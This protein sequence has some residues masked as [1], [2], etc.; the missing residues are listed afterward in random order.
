MRNLQ[1]SET[2][3]TFDK[4]ATPRMSGALPARP[5]TSSWEDPEPDTETGD[6]FSGDG[7]IPLMSGALQPASPEPG[8]WSNNQPPPRPRSVGFDGDYSGHINDHVY[9]TWGAPRHLR[10]NREDA[11]VGNE[12]AAVSNDLDDTWHECGLTNAQT[13]ETKRSA[14]PHERGS[15]YADADAWGN[16][17]NSSKE[18]PGSRG[19]WN[20]YARA[21]G[22]GTTATTEERATHVDDSWGMGNQIST[23]RYA[24]NQASRA[25]IPSIPS[26]E[27]Y[28]PA[29]QSFVS[30]HYQ[31]RVAN[32]YIQNTRFT[33]PDRKHNCRTNPDNYDGNRAGPDGS[34]V[35]YSAI[36][37][38]VPTLMD[39]GNHAEYTAWF[40]MLRSVLKYHQLTSVIASDANR[41]HSYKDGRR[42]DQDRLR[43]AIIIKGALSFEVF[44][45][46]RRNG[47]RDTDNPAET[48]EK[49]RTTHGA[50]CPCGHSQGM[51]LL[52]F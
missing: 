6:G 24:N 42:W 28:D 38:T 26:T 36:L 7:F 5:D 29:P 45:R 33:S 4:P 9:P 46:V 18:H 16:N 43:A 12:E 37:P 44:E 17:D 50:V 49:I 34:R 32:P 51:T 11:V 39:I 22:R 47:W 1:I 27:G 41:P 10:V 23:D 19:N 52:D 3:G 21:H 35:F 48:I 40:D 14:P 25:T 15:N 20:E 30:Q 31:P 13:G 8:S 2:E